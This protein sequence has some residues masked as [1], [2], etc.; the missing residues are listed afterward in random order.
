MDSIPVRFRELSEPCP[1]CGGP[2]LIVDEKGI[3]VNDSPDGLVQWMP[4]RWR[5]AAGCRLIADDDPEETV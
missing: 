1:L 4:V 5:C 2:D 3:V